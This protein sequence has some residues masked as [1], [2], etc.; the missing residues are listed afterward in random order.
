MSALKQKLF[1]EYGGFADH[2]IKDLKKSSHFIVD[3]RSPKDI[4]ADGRL[5]GYFCSLFV[6]YRSESEVKLRLAGNIPSSRKITTWIEK[7]GN[8]SKWEGELLF[9][10]TPKNIG[11]LEELAKALEA[12]VAPDAPRYEEPSCKYVCPRTAESLR[13][14]ARTLSSE[15]EG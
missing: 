2:R 13:R 15:W 10:I 14:L 3:D 12:I 1:T 9:S 4:G 8:S 7:A 5:L 6:D 11:L